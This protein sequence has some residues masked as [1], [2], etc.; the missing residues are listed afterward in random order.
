MITNLANQL[1]PWWEQN[2]SDLPW[3]TAVSDTPP[4]PY[5][6]WVSEIMAQ[7]TQLATVIPYFERWMARF[8]TVQALATAPLDDVLKRWEGLGY[9]S[10]A[11]N[12]H[13]AAQTIMSQHDG[14]LPRTA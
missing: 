4:D 2:H 10:R 8:P 12:M 14:H 11:R 6:I 9:Y 13:T 7:Q 5:A 1:L 3:R